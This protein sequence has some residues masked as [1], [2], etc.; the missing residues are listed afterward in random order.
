MPRTNDAINI[1]LISKVSSMYYNQEYN[2]Q[3]IAD[4]LQLS[5]PKVSRLLKQARQQ[6]IV[7]ISVIAPSGNF[8]KIEEA[9]E[10][11]FGLQEVL[12]VD[13]EN[14]D[15]KAIKRQIGAAAAS[16]LDR[17]IS[18]GD[19][20]GVAWGT[21]L[22]A[23]VEAMHPKP[24][25]NIRIVQALGGVGPPE[26]K[27]HASDI[28]RRLAQLLGG[29]LTLLPAPGIVSS[30][31]AKQVL[32]SDSQVRGALDL[33]SKLDT[34]YVGLGALNTNPVL[35]ND[36][37]EIPPGFYE[38]VIKSEAVGDIALHFFDAKGGEVETSLKKCVIG[39]SPKEIKEVDTVV[40]MAGGQEKV[41]VIRGALN[42]HYIN[43]LITNH[44]TAAKLLEE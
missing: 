11:K 6:G 25:K 8:M 12:I 36:R 40:G 17:T 2:Q 44:Q 4:R 20:I 10:K 9:L 26:A 14:S 22:H 30:K 43:V 34:L 32:I 35:K 31:E 15:A 5:R 7:Q 39:I 33:F 24:I 1:R 42:G 23:M 28:S 37:E 38:E 27:A 21:T 41:D 29:K 16:Y 13:V 18:Q 3:E 19:L